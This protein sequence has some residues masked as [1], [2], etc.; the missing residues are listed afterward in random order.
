MGLGRE[1]RQGSR[2][3]GGERKG[4][5][6][7]LGWPEHL[8]SVGLTSAAVPADSFVEPDGTFGGVA[9]RPEQ[10]SNFCRPQY[11]TST[12]FSASATSPL[13]RH[14][15]IMRLSGR[16]RV[17]SNSAAPQCS[18]C[19]QLRNFQNGSAPRWLAERAMVPRRLL[20]D[21]PVCACEGRI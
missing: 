20:N 9:Q 17:A 7:C 3:K 2:N 18:S 6:R 21:L 13:Q 15:Q 10:L 12:P 8:S 5:S 19:L 16:Y 1:R 14:S 11:I 4:E